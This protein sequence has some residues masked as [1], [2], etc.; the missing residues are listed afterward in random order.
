MRD[1][2]RPTERGDTSNCWLG[3]PPGV[4]GIHDEDGNV[5]VPLVKRL[6]S[7]INLV[8][9]AGSERAKLSGADEN[10]GLMKECVNINKSL[11]AL[12]NVIAALGE[13]GRTMHVPY[14]ESKLTQLLEESLGGNAQTVM[15]NAVSVSR[16][17]AARQFTPWPQANL[18]TVHLLCH[19]RAVH[20]WS[21]ALQPL[22]KHHAETLSTL[23]WAK[24]AQ[25]IINIATAGVAIDADSAME[26][27][28]AV[29][30][31]Q[32]QVST[33]YSSLD[34]ASGSSPL[35]LTL[36]GDR[37]SAAGCTGARARARE[38]AARVSSTDRNRA[39][40]GRC[41]AARCGS[42]GSCAGGGLRT[43]P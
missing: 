5:A 1:R 29:A 23:Q 6:R 2:P 41:G 24:R 22:V 14:R 35:R 8:D 32:K 40:A 16:T 30:K 26:K 18:A 43:A 17:N 7:K 12:G 36:A 4:D 11:S 28:A 31:L 15:I 34:P 21:C 13:G 27:M 33:A 9:L 37:R 42:S 25:S 20:V 39:C 10:A 38:A 3:K 19:S